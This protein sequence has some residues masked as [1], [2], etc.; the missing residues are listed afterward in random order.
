VTRRVSKALQGGYLNDV[1]T[2]RG[3]PKR[4]VI[5]D[6]LPDERSLLPTPEEVKNK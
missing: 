6:T 5:G 2:K 3:Q 4:L 1:E